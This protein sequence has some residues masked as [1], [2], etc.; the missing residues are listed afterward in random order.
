MTLNRKLSDV[1]WQ[2]VI[3]AV[4]Q[5]VVRSV[6]QLSPPLKLKM[7]DS[8]M[9]MK[10]EQASASALMPLSNRIETREPNLAAG[11]DDSIFFSI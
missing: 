1:W 7:Q 6:P 5:H 2:Q 9:K 4:F 3:K 10:P 11:R 8:N